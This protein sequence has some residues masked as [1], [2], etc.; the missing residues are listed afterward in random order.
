[1][2][3]RWLFLAL[4]LASLMAGCV[5]PQ[6]QAFLQDD[7]AWAKQVTTRFDPYKSVTITQGEDLDNSLARVFLRSTRSAQFPGVDGIVIYVYAKLENWKFLSSAY[8]IDG[9]RFD[10]VVLDRDVRFCTRYGCSLAEHLVL[11]TNRQYLRKHIERGLD[12]RLDGQRGNHPIY[13]P[14][15]YIVAFLASLPPERANTPTY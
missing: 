15:A 10:T 1:M 7:V 4:G 9:H 12:I 6:Q 14:P 11:H 13:L 8:G 2:T 5:T 3:Q